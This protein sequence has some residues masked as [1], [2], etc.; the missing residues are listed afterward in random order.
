MPLQVY[1][2]NCAQYRHEWCKRKADSPDPDLLRDC[3]YYRG[4]TNADCIRA[5]SDEELAEFIE[6]IAPAKGW[7]WFLQNGTWLDWLKKE[8]D[9]YYEQQIEEYLEGL[10]ER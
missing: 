8:N 9:A 7:S 4:I 2:R 10:N 5:M 6:S 1:C 3:Q